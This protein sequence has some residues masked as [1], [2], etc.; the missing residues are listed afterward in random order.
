MG[1][2]EYYENPKNREAEGLTPEEQVKDMGAEKSSIS[3]H[4]LDK[5]KKT[6]RYFRLIKGWFRYETQRQADNRQ[7]RMKAHE[8]KDG[9]QWDEDDKA[10]I[11]G[12]GQKACV[13][14]LTKP[15][16]DWITGTEK[17]TRVDFAVLPRRKDDSKE[18]ETKTKTIKYNDDVN[19]AGFARSLAFEDSVVSGLGWTDQGARSDESDD[20]LYSRY[21]DWRNVWHDSHAKERDLSDARYLFRSKVVDYDIAVAMFPDRADCVR[22]ALQQNDD[23]NELYYDVDEVG[24]DVEDDTVESGIKRDRVRLISCEYRLPAKAKV[25]R[26]KELGSLNGS[27]YDPENVGMKYLVDEGHASI[28]DAIK[29]DMWK[30]IFCGN[31]VLQNRKR[32][33]NHDRFSLVPYWGYRRK[34]DG[35]PYGVVKNLIDP[36]DDLNKRRSKALYILSTKQSMAESGAIDDVEDFVEERDRPDGHM[37]VNSLDKVKILDNPALAREHIMLMEQDAKYI[38]STGGVTDENRGVETNATSGKAIR[39]RQDQ[40]HVNTATLFDNYRYAFQIEGEIKLSLTEQFYTEEKTI[41][42]TGDKGQLD[43]VEINKPGDDGEIENDITATQADFIVEADNYH[44]TVRQAMFES[45]GEIVTK[46]PPEIS[47]QLLDMWIDLSDLP[48]KDVMVERIR[49]ING[50]ADP[51]EDPDDPEVQAKKEAEAAEMERQQAIE[52]QLLALDMAMKEAEVKLK[53]AQTDGQYAE[54]EKDLADAK[55]KLAGIRT[56]ME[57]TRI[58]KAKVLNDIESK[59]KGE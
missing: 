30:M 53:E 36:Q 19:K 13:F 49:A 10:D 22:A 14:N 3:K 8:Y 12:R 55:A 29:M 31:Y 2:P 27:V 58:E 50:Q 54:A 42:I 26:G 16:C 18:A 38:E 51:D 24:E 52:D 33:Y 48:G 28:V 37:E 23:I 5:D 57:K 32:I 1:I 4:H 56:D 43:F 17:R 45:F 34:K 20:P 15:T 44:A 40:G 35:M 7:E 41:R 9:E 46:L 25:I 6:L 47:L 21:E 39:A 11:E 59:E